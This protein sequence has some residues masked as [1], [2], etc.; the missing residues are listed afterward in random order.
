M[1]RT[2]PGLA[3]LVLLVAFATPASAHHVWRADRLPLGS[4]HLAG[5]GGSRG[6][7]SVSVD[8]DA[9][10]LSVDFET[11]AK[12][13]TPRLMKIV[14]PP[15]STHDDGVRLVRPAGAHGHAEWRFPEPAI[16]AGRMTVTIDEPDDDHAVRG[17]IERLVD[18]AQS[19]ASI[20][21]L[22]LLALAF[23]V[24]AV[25]VVATRRRPEPA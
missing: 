19:S 16:L 4:G 12:D 8:T 9:N 15:R 21:T 10:V 11:G 14:G 13:A 3:A 20:T 5:S 22:T 24:L 18:A 1:A 17:R 7:M 2:S 23:A 6:T 25:F